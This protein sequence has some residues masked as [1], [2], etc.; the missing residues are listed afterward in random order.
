MESMRG[1]RSTA[2]SDILPGVSSGNYLD[3]ATRPQFIDDQPTVATPPP[4]KSF[5]DHHNAGLCLPHKA[6]YALF[7]NS[8]DTSAR[9][10]S[11]EED[12]LIVVMYKAQLWAAITEKVDL[13]ELEVEALVWKLGPWEIARRAA[14]ST[15]GL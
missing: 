4:H 5:D 14:V 6:L 9:T 2:G 11:K 7:T 13:P 3:P 12:A 1:E 10:W 15:S 8:G